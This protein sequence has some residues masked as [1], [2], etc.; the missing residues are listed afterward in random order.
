ML[1]LY[2]KYTEILTKAKK[3]RVSAYAGQST[4]FILISL[5]PFVMLLMTFLH[6]LPADSEAVTVITKQIL[7]EGVSDFAVGIIEEIRGLSQTR[8]I[9][10]LTSATALWAASSGI[11]SIIRALDAINGT[12]NGQNYFIIRGK[13]AFYALMFALII[14]AVLLILTL[15][16][17]VFMFITGLKELTFLTSLFRVGII[18]LLLTAFFTVI[19]VYVPKNK[20]KIKT[21]L[22][23]AV[24]CACIWIVF[25]F[26]YSLYIS[27]MGIYSKTYGSLTAAVLLM[28]W[29]YYCIYFMLMCAEVNSISLKGQNNEK[30]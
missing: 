27:R 22:P 3:D 30:N 2:R 24:L 26:L 11:L 25:S 17:N 4:F 14:T 29:L 8:A 12:E 9:L 1:K 19:Y 23:G 10:S 18:F 21:Q 15:G 7:P 16:N 13:A 20:L 5:F 6:Y 28:L